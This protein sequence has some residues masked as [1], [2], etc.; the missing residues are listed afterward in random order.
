[1][2][3]DTTGVVNVNIILKQISNDKCKTDQYLN[4]QS[5][6]SRQKKVQNR[7]ISER[8]SLDPV[9]DD[10][11]PFFYLEWWGSDVWAA[12]WWPRR[13]DP[14]CWPAL[15]RLRLTPCFGWRPTATRSGHQ[16]RTRRCTPR[17]RCQGHPKVKSKCIKCRYILNSMQ[18]RITLPIL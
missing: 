4:S 10:S 5:L 9:S 8:S 3:W 6:D 11:D 12:S 7:K 17:T 16:G 18:K 1:M 2:F 14:R 15:G 13:V